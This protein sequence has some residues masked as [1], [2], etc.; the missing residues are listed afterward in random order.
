MSSEFTKKQIRDW[1]EASIKKAANP[2]PRE[3]LKREREVRRVKVAR[4]Y[5]L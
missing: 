1:I 2:D 3:K 4:S 5:G